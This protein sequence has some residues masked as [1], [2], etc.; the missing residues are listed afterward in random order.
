MDFPSGPGI[1]NPPA[2]VWNMGS[3]PGPGR[4]HMPQGKQAHAPTCLKPELRSK[5]SHCSEKLTHCNEEPGQPKI[6]K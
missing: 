1:K 5:R 3:V 2:N 6:N 4:F